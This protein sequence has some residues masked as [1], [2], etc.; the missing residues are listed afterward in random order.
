MILLSDNNL[1]TKKLIVIR[2]DFVY[3]HNFKYMLN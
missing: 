1:F 3:M 2:K